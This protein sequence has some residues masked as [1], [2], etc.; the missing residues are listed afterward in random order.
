MKEYEHLAAVI[1]VYTLY[2]LELRDQVPWQR[3][4][5]LLL[6]GYCFDGKKGGRRK[7]DAMLWPSEGGGGFNLC[8]ELAHSLLGYYFAYSLQFSCWF[9]HRGVVEQ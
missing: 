4:L 8:W 5:D 9:T 1:I 2:S 7:S 3:S 6:L